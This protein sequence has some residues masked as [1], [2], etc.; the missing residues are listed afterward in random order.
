[1]EVYLH[2]SCCG[3]F[4]PGE[5]APS[6]HSI[7]SWMGLRADMDAILKRRNP[8]PDLAGS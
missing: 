7:G 3:C 6:T 4:T 8:L 5:R 2:A 1:V